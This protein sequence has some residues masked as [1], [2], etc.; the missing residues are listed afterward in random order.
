MV[1]ATVEESSR[2][3]KRTV[4]PFIFLSRHSGLSLVKNASLLRRHF[5][6]LRAGGP[7]RSDRDDMRREL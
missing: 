3:L 5:N 2:V 7:R 4:E 6:D 1:K